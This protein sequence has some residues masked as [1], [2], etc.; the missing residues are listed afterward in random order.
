MC[1]YKVIK[2]EGGRELENGQKASTFEYHNIEGGAPLFH[3]STLLSA[4]LIVTAIMSFITMYR[5]GWDRLHV[6]SHHSSLGS[7]MNKLCGVYSHSIHPLSKI[8]QQVISITNWNIGLALRNDTLVSL[9]R[10]SPKSS[11]GRDGV[12]VRLKFVWALTPA[13]GFVGE[14]GALGR[15]RWMNIGYEL[16]DCEFLAFWDS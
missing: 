14:S 12:A 15:I 13:K 8:M 2:I 10:T 4:L 6:K 3:F 7:T 5:S 11:G 9:L 16:W 1:S